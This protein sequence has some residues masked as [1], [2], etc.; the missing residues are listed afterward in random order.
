VLAC[1][2]VGCCLGDIYLQGPRGSNNRL[3]EANR[4]R[5]NANRLFDSQN[6]NRG[7][8]NQGNLYYYT[9]ST[10][11][12]EWTNQHSCGNVNNHC[13]LVFQYMCGDLIRDGTTTTT[14]PEKLSKCDKRECNTDMEYG[15]HETWDYYQECDHRMRNKGLYTADQN[16]REHAT[17][18]R[19]NNNAQRRGYECAEERDYYP[20][21]HP[22]PWRDIVVFTN[23]VKR[24]DYYQE[25]S[26]NVKNKGYCQ[27][28]ENFLRYKYDADID[29]DLANNKEDCEVEVSHGGK[30][31]KPT[32][33]ETGAHAVPAPEC[34]PSPWSRDNHHGNNKDGFMNSYNWTIPEDWVEEKCVIRLRYNITAGELNDGGFDP[35]INASLNAEKDDAPT[36]IKIAHLYGLDEEEA[37]AR[38]YQFQQDPVLQIFKFNE[39]DAEINLEININTN[40]FGR[41][42][43]DRSHV[44]EIRKR[45]SDVSADAKIH[46][47]NVRGKRGNIVQ[48]YPGVEY[49][50]QPNRLEVKEGEYIHIQWTGADSNPQNNAGQGRAGTDRSNMLVLRDRTWDNGYVEDAHGCFACNYPEAWTKDTS[51]NFLG[52]A[53]E[54]IMALAFLSPT[55]YWGDMDELDD[56]GTYFDMGLR[57]MTKSGIWRYLCTRNNNFT[58]RSQKGEIRV[59]SA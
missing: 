54:D 25:E 59:I 10:L 13:E 33:I 36:G 23:D 52:L 42:F 2:L 47:L 30:S 9:G 51:P 20:Y 32:W 4:E 56:A 7:G 38:G 35:A 11:T 14:I 22:T 29:V 55:Q 34:L 26:Q 28:P 49:D 16:M 50:F 46:N 48:T 24:C 6:N 58:N 39:G 5:N 41:T 40:Q 21:W 27:Y 57:K 43:E 8:Y 17:S 53:R 37:V 3:N 45:P 44:F 18:T 12:L 1:I 31:V 15:M 19:Q